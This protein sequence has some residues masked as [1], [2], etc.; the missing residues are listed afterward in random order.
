M[1]GAENN[2]FQCE[3]NIIQN[4]TSASNDHEDD[5]LAGFAAL[6]P[7]PPERRPTCRSCGSTFIKFFL[8]LPTLFFF[9]FPTPVCLCPYF[10]KKC[11]DLST[12]VYIVQHPHEESRVLR[13][14]PLLTASLSPDKCHIIKGKR[15]SS[16]KHAEL[17]AICSNPNALLL[18][19]GPEAI[20]ITKVPRLP[21]DQF[22][23]LIIID[24]TWPQAKYIFNN[25]KMLKI[26]KQVQFSNVGVSQYVIRTQPKD[27]ALST[28][29]SAALALSIL[30]DRPELQDIL[31]APLKAL[32]QFQLEHGAV[33]HQSKESKE[34]LQKKNEPPQA[35]EK[36]K[37][38]PEAV[39]DKQERSDR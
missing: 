10:P 2:N 6:E 33:I 15:L 30:E 26:P 17:E 7:D 29:E 39:E 11:L 21:C 22:Y 28:V 35:T 5:V 24:G 1:D 38:C 23:S 32:C 16:V 19:P 12:S 31:L 20:D 37:S 3:N 36:N 13:T 9:F 27:G 14:A 34:R 8:S 18:Y 25:N 4:G